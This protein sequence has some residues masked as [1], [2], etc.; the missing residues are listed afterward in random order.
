MHIRIG[1]LSKLLDVRLQR[2]G[3]G[4]RDLPGRP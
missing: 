3:N 2:I 4:E 1:V